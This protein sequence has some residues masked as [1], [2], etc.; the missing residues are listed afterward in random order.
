MEEHSLTTS[1]CVLEA[2]W[3]GV[4]AGVGKPWHMRSECKSFLLFMFAVANAQGSKEQV[5]LPECF[6]EGEWLDGV[7]EG[8][9]S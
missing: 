6:L 7:R 4:L 3:S 2:T 1:C 8:E 9:M 5:L